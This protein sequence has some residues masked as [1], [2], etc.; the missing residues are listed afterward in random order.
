M[1]RAKDLLRSHTCSIYD[2]LKDAYGYSVNIW[3]WEKEIAEEAI[4]IAYAC[5]T[6]YRDLTRGD[7]SRDALRADIAT[8]VGHALRSGPVQKALLQNLPGVS[9]KSHGLTPPPSPYSLADVLTS[10]QAAAY[11]RSGIDLSSTSP[12]LIAAAMQANIGQ[13]SVPPPS[14]LSPP[15]PSLVEQRRALLE[16]YRSKTGASHHKIYTA[17]NSCIHKPEFYAWVKERC[18][19]RQPPQSTSSGFCAAR[20]R[21]SLAKQGSFLPW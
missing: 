14:P 11:A 20:S 9:G 12:L 15:E 2:A 19:V 6:N 5:W 16:A 21:R 17:S 13:E 18:P 1:P 8:H 4:D 7:F 10:Q 3:E